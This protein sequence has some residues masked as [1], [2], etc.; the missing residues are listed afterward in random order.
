MFEIGNSLREARLRQ[1]L[2]FPELEQ[3][4]KIR[5]KYLRA[6][7]DEQFDVLPAQ[8][9]VKGF[10]RSYAEYL[11]LDG[12]LYVDEYNSRFVVGE[13][14]HP[15]S[16]PRRSAPPPSSRG[17]QV[18]S[19][20]V[21]L[22]LLGIVSVTALVI[23][24]WTRGEP[25]TVTPIRPRNV[26]AADAPDSSRTCCDEDGPSAREGVAWFVLAAGPQDIRDRADPLPGHARSGT[27]ATLHRAKVVDHA[28]SPR[29]PRH[30]F[31]RTH[32]ASARRRREDPDRDAARHPPGRVTARP[33]AFIV[34]TG[35]ELVR[36]E[37]R[38]LNGPFL[39]GELLRLGVEP[40]RISIVGDREEELM[41]ALAEGL[42]SADLCVVSGGLGPTHDDRTVELVA[43]AAG[44]ELRLD[45]DLH[46]QIGSISRAFAE[47]LGRPYVDF[48]AGVRKQATIPEGAL[49]LGL[50]GTAPG[51]VLEH[52]DTVVVVLP[53]PPA[54]L[55]RL[56]REA[57][58]SE[59]VR[60]LAR[61]CEASGAAA[62][63]LLRR[64]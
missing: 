31:E 42:A 9:Y 27:E 58:E 57:V 22:T 29:E 17:V 32:A 7:E 41:G 20:V 12:Q 33:R 47:R 23:V 26:E 43:R 24:A 3:G 63:A 1:G 38:D 35:S 18:Q 16:R 34:V 40:A 52:G 6:L 36:G 62:A 53:G 25:Q 54:E 59:P 48:E 15:Q 55:Q 49:S 60:R 44:V 4:T 2:D 28:R 56:W 37:R 21:L 14:E 50:A 10:L 19:R 61:E 64:Q 5:G 39:A 11:G 51:L 13:E 45:E 8:T 30:Y 46:E